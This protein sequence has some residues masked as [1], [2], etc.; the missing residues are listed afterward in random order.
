MVTTTNDILLPSN[1][2]I[3]FHL[4]LVGAHGP[5]AAEKSEALVQGIVRY[6]ETQTDRTGKRE[7]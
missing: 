5:I 3:S 2:I 6:L 4:S 1:V 7:R